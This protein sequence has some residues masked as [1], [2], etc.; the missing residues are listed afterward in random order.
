M[1]AI[2]AYQ[3]HPQINSHLCSACST[4]FERINYVPYPYVFRNPRVQFYK[5]E[6]KAP[7]WN[8]TNDFRTLAASSPQSCHL[9]SKFLAH[10][11]RRDL[12]ILEKDAVPGSCGMMGVKRLTKPLEYQ[13]CLGFLY[14]PNGSNSGNE[15]KGTKYMMSRLHLKPW[16]PGNHFILRK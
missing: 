16:K 8:H 11:S 5:D 3:D 2:L 10:L 9:C 6:R 14:Y 1:P 7:M 4:I 15:M 13:V 12:E